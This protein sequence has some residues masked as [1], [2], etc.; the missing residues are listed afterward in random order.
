M[1]M[2]QLRRCNS[3]N[4]TSVLSTQYP[5]TS[6]NPQEPHRALKFPYIGM[7]VAKVSIAF[8]AVKQISLRGHPIW[9]ALDDNNRFGLERQNYECTGN[10]IG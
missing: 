5:S 3:N 6:Q 4:L 7:E 1:I 2:L 8:D 10:G 9:C